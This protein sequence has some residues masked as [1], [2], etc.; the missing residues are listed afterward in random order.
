MVKAGLEPPDV[1]HMDGKL[2]RFN[3]GTKGAG[4]HAKPG[5]YVLFSDGIPAG[6]FGC[7]RAGLEV[8]FRADV[9]RVLSSV[10]DMANTMRMAEAR[11]LR[12]AE[13]AR[14]RLVAADTVEAIWSSCT[15][16]DADHP[17][18]KRKG[19]Q[20]HGSRVTG[21]GR[22]VVPLFDIDGCLS[23]LQYIAH[24]GSKLYHPGGQTGSRF[25]MLGT[26]DEPGVLY[27]AEGFATAATINE[28]T[29]R[30]CV[31]AYSASNLV[32]ATGAMREAHGV[33]QDIVV[34][35]DHDASGVGQRYAE[36]ASAKFGS[37]MVMPTI[38]GDAN[39]YAQAGHNLAALL[40]P[41][42]L[43]L[44]VV[45]ADELSETFSPADEIVEGVLTSGDGSLLYGGSNSGKTF[46]VIDMACAVAR[47]VDWM[48]RKTEQGLVIYIAAESPASIE[49]RLQ[50]YQQ[51]YK[52]R[53]P[54]FAIVQ[55]PIN[56][57][58]GDDDTNAIILLVR[59]VEEQRGKKVRLIVGDTLARLSAGAN[60]NAGQDMGLVVER[61]DR[62]RKECR[63]HF[64]LIHHSGKNAAAGS[65]GWSG[66]RAAVETEI[67]VT[68]SP[69]GHCAEIMKQ[70]DL[71]TKGE[72][73]GFGLE[74][75]VLGETKWGKPATS[76]VVV[77]SSVAVAPSKKD[78]KIAVHIKTLDNAWW[79]SSAE[80]RSGAPYISRSG[81]TEY[82]IEKLGLSEASAKQYLKPS[83]P[84]K[85]ISDLLLSGI[86]EAF[87]TGWVILDNV[88]A[89][90][91]MLRRGEM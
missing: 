80:V 1:V 61:F 83:V 73:I 25:W 34:V 26:L 89:S 31:V 74:A 68:D 78:N 8:T 59:Q 23:S 2:H 27:V 12:D 22:L 70:R 37:R 54:D 20:T 18:L 75:V 30:P 29:G 88:L 62:I 9:G 58:D 66:V 3:S 63:A 10:E 11:T 47:G 67:E 55:N 52:I 45:F 32:P 57:F 16:A 85:L 56:L 76:C 21:D 51:H 7:W 39:D 64:L 43:A 40:A 5:W 36:Q 4:G 24:D 91:M 81:L 79:D 77:A 60:E 17:Y 87:E 71:A 42:S 46:F 49:R 72:L 15:P 41:A 14:T 48:G 44:D 13:V 19:I 38:L 53:V 50:A 90:S 86:I 33:G 35:A 69:S 82:L 65:R 84:G 6:R 28:T